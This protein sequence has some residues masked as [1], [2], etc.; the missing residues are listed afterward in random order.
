MSGLLLAVAVLAMAGGSGVL[1]GVSVAAAAA[2]EVFG[3]LWRRCSRAAAQV[4]E[5]LF[6]ELAAGEDSPGD[7]SSEWCADSDQ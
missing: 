4:E 3:G 1:V 2:V 5:I 6:T 7:K